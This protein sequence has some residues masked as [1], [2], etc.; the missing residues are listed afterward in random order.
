M[1]LLEEMEEFHRDQSSMS[2]SQAAARRQGI[3]T[4]LLRLKPGAASGIQAVKDASGNVVTE[5]HSMAK[6]LSEHWR[7]TFA[8]Q[9]IDEQALS[10]W[11]EATLPLGG[12]SSDG[13]PL[14]EVPFGDWRLRWEDIDAAIRLSGKSAPG[15]EGTL[16]G[17]NTRCTWRYSC[18]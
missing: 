4:K 2:D 17:A 14:R 18:I 10:R 1:G 5:P 3:M 6:A 16:Q 7:N 12:S 13:K 11:L 9:P 15:P 8:H